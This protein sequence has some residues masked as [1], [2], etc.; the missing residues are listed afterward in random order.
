MRVDERLLR[1]QL[2]RG[3]RYAFRRHVRERVARTD[4]ICAV[5]DAQL[6]RH[7]LLVAP[8][9]PDPCCSWHRRSACSRVISAVLV[10]RAPLVRRSSASSAMTHSRL[11]RLASTSER[12]AT[13]A[14]DAW[15]DPLS[16]ARATRCRRPRSATR[17]GREVEHLVAHAGR[18]LRRSR[19]ARFRSRPPTC[20]RRS[21]NRMRMRRAAQGTPRQR[22]RVGKRGGRRW[23]LADAGAAR[24]IRAGSR[25]AAVAIGSRVA[26]QDLRETRGTRVQ[27]L[28]GHLVQRHVGGV[29]HRRACRGRSRRRRSAR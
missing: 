5:G 14:G 12:C 18:G 16:L 7:L 6:R 24:P 3:C 26:L 13:C 17:V 28:V 27:L 25:A 23:P 20:R 15:E 1:P 11:R 8:C 29:R 19:G 9:A 22:V 10:G 4:A 2:F 21:R